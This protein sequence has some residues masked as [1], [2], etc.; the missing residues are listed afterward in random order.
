[1]IAQEIAGTDW[2]IELTKED[3]FIAPLVF[4]LMSHPGLTVLIEMPPELNKNN[5][6]WVISAGD[7]CPGYW[8]RHTTTK[9]DAIK[10]CDDFNLA[11]E[12]FE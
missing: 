3:K 5:P 1:M 4:A 12:I 7:L 6:I 11:Y 9:E 8:L 2:G 10:F